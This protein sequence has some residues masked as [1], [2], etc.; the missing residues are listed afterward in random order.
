MPVICIPLN[1]AQSDLVAILYNLPPA[2]HFRRHTLSPFISDDLQ[3]MVQVSA[4][5]STNVKRR[6]RAHERHWLKLLPLFRPSP[7]VAPLLPAK[8]RH[9]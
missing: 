7:K 3:I 8:S 9:G 1:P 4:V 2:V 6:E 5:V